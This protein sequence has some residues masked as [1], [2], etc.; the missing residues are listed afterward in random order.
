M[1]RT[2]I[3]FLGSLDAAEE[4]RYRAALSAAMP[5]EVVR[6][7]RMLTQAERAAVEIAIV[8]N[9]D[10]SEV[11]QLPRL[12]W[13]QSLWAGVERLVRDLGPGAPPIVR[14]VDPELARTMAEAVL[15][16][17]Y[18]LQRDMP[19]YRRQQETGL[20]RQRPYRAPADTTVG[21]LGLGALGKAAAQRLVQ[22]G[23]RVA[24]WTR[25][26]PAEDG[27]LAGVAT[28]FGPDGLPDLLGR[29][30]IVV[31]L[32]PL[33][34]ETHGLLDAGRLAAMKPGAALIN[35]ARGAIVV[36]D[37]L[38]A[39]LDTGHLEHA[40]LDVFETEPLPTA[41]PLWRH[42]KITVLP[43]VT[44]PTNHGSAAAVV[45]SNLRAYRE[46]RRVPAA[47]DVARGY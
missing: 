31:C 27:S 46:T 24:A 45:A 20:W 23:F 41:S 11:A 33:T 12:A 44:G 9:P 36:T 10:P 18:Y 19:A 29:S 13:I 21:L 4:E 42:P 1:Q 5:E 47:V 40:V 28:A 34:A 6:P 25:S 7:F 3:A 14:L 35:V 32:L 17:T 22:A 37:A 43:H 30:D 39:A 16:W 38:I 26:A 15:A 2:P 8:A